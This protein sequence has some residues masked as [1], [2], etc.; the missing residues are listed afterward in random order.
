MAWQRAAATVLPAQVKTA[1]WYLIAA[2]GQQLAAVLGAREVGKALGGAASALA[3]TLSVMLC[4][5]LLVIVSTTVVLM[6]TA[7]S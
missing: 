3:V 1:V 5:A 7:A 6:L 4:F 2:A